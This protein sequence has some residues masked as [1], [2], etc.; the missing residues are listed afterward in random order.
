MCRAVYCMCGMCRVVCFV[1]FFNPRGEML[2]CDVCEGKV[3]P[4]ARHHI[5]VR[6]RHLAT[7]QLCAESHRVWTPAPE[8][9]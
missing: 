4:Y 9:A 3:L 6:P 5:D 7:I 8:S 2:C 1:L